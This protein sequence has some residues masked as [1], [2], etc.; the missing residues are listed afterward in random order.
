MMT[1]S[2]PSRH[3]PA[4]LL[5]LLL[6]SFHSSTVASFVATPTT[7]TAVQVLLAPGRGVV[8]SPANTVVSSTT[9]L[10]FSKE[11]SK[12]TDY[13]DDAFGLVFLCGATVAEDAVFSSLFLVLSAVAAIATKQGKLPSNNQVPAAVAGV[14][15]LLTV[16]ILLNPLDVV[17]GDWSNTSS[18]SPSATW[19]EVALCMASMVYGFVLAPPPADQET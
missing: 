11:P 6:V 1:I 19:I 10:F 8:V 3:H 13:N 18:K 16:G 9:R 4:L 2:T 7:S 15:L 17:L 5:W 14:T 12:T